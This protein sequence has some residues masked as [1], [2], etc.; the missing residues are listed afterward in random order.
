MLLLVANGE[1]ALRL[2]VVLC[3]GREGLDRLAREHRH[4]E[5]GIGG[6][7]LV[8]GLEII[9][10]ATLDILVSRLTK[11]R[12]SSGRAPNVTFSALCISSP[13][14]SKNLPQPGRESASKWVTEKIGVTHLRGTEC[15]Q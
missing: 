15:P 2:L 6:R 8:A 7:V 5:L 14:P 1:L 9:S 4:T 11:T 3:E 10:M 13:L 12:V